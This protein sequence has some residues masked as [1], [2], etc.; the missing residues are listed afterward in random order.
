M[1]YDFYQILQVPSTS[2]AE[3]IQK[4]YKKQLLR[5]H[6]DKNPDDPLASWQ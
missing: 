5:Y 6:P 4:A 1:D 3:E 2:S